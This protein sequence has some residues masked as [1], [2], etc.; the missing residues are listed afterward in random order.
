MTNL[1]SYP[2]LN[3]RVWKKT[4]RHLK[5]IDSVPSPNNTTSDVIGFQQKIERGY[6]GYCFCYSSIANTE[7]SKTYT[8]S[9]WS[10]TNNPNFNVTLYTLNN[11]S[12]RQSKY[13]FYAAKKVTGDSQWHKLSWE[14]TNPVNLK[15]KSVNFRLHGGHTGQ[16]YLYNPVLLEKVSDTNTNNNESTNSTNVVSLQT[17]SNIYKNNIDAVV[18]IM[19]QA[20]NNYLYSGTGFFISDDGYIVTAAH[21]VIQGNTAPEPYA[22]KSLDSLLSRKSHNRSNYHRGRPTLRCRFN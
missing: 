20:Q 3:H 14:F 18:N 1:I 13:T 10:R 16:N 8:V 2:D 7:Y 11:S 22:K 17:F 15:T 9:I 19:M 5:R 21:V 4:W 6:Y 12:D